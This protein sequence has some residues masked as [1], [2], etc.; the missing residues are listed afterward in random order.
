M[1]QAFA[2]TPL[3]GVDA[4]AF[5]DEVV[6][7]GDV[8]AGGPSGR[9]RRKATRREVACRRSSSGRAPSSVTPTSPT[10]PAS[11]RR[12]SSSSASRG[13]CSAST[14]RLGTRASAYS[15]RRRIMTSRTC[16]PARRPMFSP[17]VTP[18]CNSCAPSAGAYSSIPVASGC[19]CTR[20]PIYDRNRRAARGARRRVRVRRGRRHVRHRAAARACRHRVARARCPLLWPAPSELVGSRARAADR[21]AQRPC[22]Q[23][24][25]VR[26]A[27]LLAAS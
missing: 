1:A 24:R 18:I 16:S 9:C 12:S 22:S 10:S 23:P 27:D 26:D 19:R 11:C 14:A 5:G 15:R 4:V 2:S 6:C 25:E 7:L 21:S 20:V 8:A 17:A 3:S 13:D